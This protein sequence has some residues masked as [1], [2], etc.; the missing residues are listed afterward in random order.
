MESGQ[1]KAVYD[2]GFSDS[3]ADMKVING[4]L[5]LAW[6]KVKKQITGSVELD[7][8]GVFQQMAENAEIYYAELRTRGYE[9]DACC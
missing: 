2:D 4:N 3:Y 8:T 1:P 6:Q 5:V 9:S 7:S